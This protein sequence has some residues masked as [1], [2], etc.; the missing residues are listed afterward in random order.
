MILNI[1]KMSENFIQ[2]LQF[3]ITAGADFNQVNNRG[4]TP[5]MIAERYGHQDIIRFLTKV[6]NKGYLGDFQRV[7][8]SARRTASSRQAQLE[9]HTPLNSDLARRISRLSLNGFG[10]KK[11]RS[12]LA[13]LKRD[14]GYLGKV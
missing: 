10:K 7:A 2:I 3:L 13:R 1:N 4:E 8:R 9:K 11:Q 6:M 5:L 14:L 12:S